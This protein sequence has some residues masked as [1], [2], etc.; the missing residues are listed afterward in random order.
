MP[1]E[2]ENRGSG[3]TEVRGE[4][5]NPDASE[6]A[7]A[8]EKPG[9][10]GGAEEVMKSAPEDAEQVM[11]PA[12]PEGA[13]Q[14]MSPAAPEDAEQVSKPAAPEDAGQV[15]KPEAPEDAGQVLKLAASE[16][17]GQALKL[18]ASEGAPENEEPAQAEE[19]ISVD[20]QIT[21]GDFLNVYCQPIGPV[22]RL[23]FSGTW[24]A[25]IGLFI[26]HG[27]TSPG[28]AQITTGFFVL[29]LI[30]LDLWVAWRIYKVGRK[31]TTATFVLR[32]EALMVNTSEGSKS[33]V[34]WKNV[35]KIEQKADA[36]AIQV[37]KDPKLYFWIPRRRFPSRAKADLFFE[38]ANEY[39]TD[40]LMV[41]S[42]ETE[43]TMP[44]SAEYDDPS[45][46]SVDV[47]LTLGELILCDAFLKKR[48]LIWGLIIFVQGGLSMI[49]SPWS[50][51]FILAIGIY[52]LVAPFIRSYRRYKK[53]PNVLSGRTTITEDGLRPFNKVSGYDT[54]LSWETIRK[55][56]VWRE[57]AFFEM[58][59]KR[60]IV[61]PLRCFKTKE[62]ADQ[63][64]A[65][66]KAKWSE[67]TKKKLTGAK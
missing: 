32:K 16:G 7:G 40:W 23:L 2:I 5:E 24:G 53:N 3:E 54:T 41:A 47:D 11:K 50:G 29:E 35:V 56:Y 63:F 9:V 1:G 14:V 18:T 8:L 62:A 28:L 36:I 66:V 59:S 48:V 55:I 27:F 22:L 17:A 42:L 30:C 21:F 45:L 19:L 57:I 58:Q 38:K 26:S 4:A 31:S 39:W 37:S 67:R 10:S 43:G 46:P 13:E 20:N 64:M 61:L 49:F 60:A 12:A 51:A 65:T 25:I 44:P 6:A 33:K 15:S 52:L 34:D